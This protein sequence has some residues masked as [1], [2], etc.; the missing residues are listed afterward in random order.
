MRAEN[1]DG[2][3]FFGM[4]TVGNFSQ[5]AQ[6]IFERQFVDVDNLSID[7]A[8]FNDTTKAVVVQTFVPGWS[9]FHGHNLDNAL[10]F[11]RHETKD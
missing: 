10:V 3:L 9:T 4:I 2:F 7:H 11:F 6:V 8:H 5:P 1:G